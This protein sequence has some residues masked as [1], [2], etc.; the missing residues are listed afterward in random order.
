MKRFLNYYNLH[1]IK[2][3]PL[4]SVKSKVIIVN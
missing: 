2:I 3:I 1:E 4:F